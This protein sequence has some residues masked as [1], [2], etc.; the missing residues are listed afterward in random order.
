MSNYR[1]SQISGESWI[2]A[3]RV[4]LENPL[5][6]VP[7]AHF[8]EEKVISVDGETIKQAMPPTLSSKMTD[9]ATSFPLLNPVDDTQ[10][11]TIT[12][13]YLYIAVYSLHRYLASLRDAPV[14]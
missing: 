2:R 6:G 10:V 3:K 8:V 13:E 7:E 9:P 14:N 5:G 4:I 11:G 12:Y 1:Q